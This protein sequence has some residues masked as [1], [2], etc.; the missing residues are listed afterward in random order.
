L[1]QEYQFWIEKRS[2]DF[3]GYNTELYLLNRYNVNNSLPRPEACITK[4]GREG[5]DERREGKERDIEI[6]G[7]LRNLFKLI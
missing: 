7:S 4:E 2:V 3:P 6:Y 1:D 5:R